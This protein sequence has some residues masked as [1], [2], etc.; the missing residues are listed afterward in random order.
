MSKE[1]S[2]VLQ[3]IFGFGYDCQ[4]GKLYD[5]D[6]IETRYTFDCTPGYN[7]LQYA[8]DE[9]AKDM[10]FMVAAC[11]LPDPSIEVQTVQN[12]LS[13][14]PQGRVV[15]VV[16]RGNGAICEMNAGLLASIMVR[17]GSHENGLK[18]LV[19]IVRAELSRHGIATNPEPQTSR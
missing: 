10:A 3:D 14:V 1:K 11:C 7:P 2:R 18:Q 5:P 15:R 8:S 16:N 9:T 19:A 4:T 6:G 13:M 12:L 17:Y